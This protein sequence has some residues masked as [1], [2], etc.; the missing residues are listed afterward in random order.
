MVRRG[1]PCGD[2]LEELSF[3]LHITPERMDRV[4][5]LLLAEGYSIHG[6]CYG[7]GRARDKLIT[8]IGDN[9]F[10]NILI[11]E[12]RKYAKKWGETKTLPNQSFT[13]AK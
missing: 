13:K 6:I 1:Y 3:D 10:D 7:A 5:K 4:K 12:V 8:F 2:T 9:R 11:N